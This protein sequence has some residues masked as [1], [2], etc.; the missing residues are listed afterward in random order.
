MDKYYK[1]ENANIR[2]TDN[3]EG[4]VIVLLHGFLESLDMWSS[5]SD[6]LSENNRVVT[7]D[8]LGHGKTDCISKVHTMSGMAVYVEIIMQHL[9][10]KKYKVVGHSMGGY[11]ALELLNNFPEK[12]E[13]LCL[14]HS[15]SFPDTLEKKLGRDQ[16]ILLIKKDSVKFIE[17]A[18]PLLFRKSTT[19]KYKQEIKDTINQ[20]LQTP[21]DG[22]VP[23]LRGMKK[24]NN[25]ERL[26]Y[27]TNIPKLI[28]IGRYDNGLPLD[29][30]IEQSEIAKNS[31]TLLLDI[32]HMG[33]IEAKEQTLQGLIDFA[34]A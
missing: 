27:D 2:Y 28:V 26:L 21:I 9:N 5:F 10:I 33:H 18:I 8:L 20:A 23:A 32:A 31:K 4:S 16:A 30:L 3:G 6:K 15:T 34:K 17:T 29:S 11:V 19:F 13:G 14:F 1:Y 12:V 25:L 24:R 7:I 22:I